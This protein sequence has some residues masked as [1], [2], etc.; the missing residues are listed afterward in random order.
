M[1][2]NAFRAGQNFRFPDDD[3]VYKFYGITYVAGVPIIKYYD[4][5]TDKTSER[6]GFDLFDITHA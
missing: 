3:K 2:A 5:Q 1:N 4:G 6:Q